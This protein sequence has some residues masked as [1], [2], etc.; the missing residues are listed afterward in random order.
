MVSHASRS[1]TADCGGFKRFAHSAGP[2]GGLEAWRRRG[3]E[4]KCLGG[5]RWGTWGILGV[6]RGAPGGSRGWVPEDSLGGAWEV[7]GMSLGVPGGPCGG[8]LGGSLGGPWGSWRDAKEPR[9]LQD[10][11]HDPFWSQ[12]GANLGQ[13][14]GKLGKTWTQM[15]PK[16]VPRK[17]KNQSKIIVVVSF[18]I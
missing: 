15:A 8:S 12:P 4:D 18:K 14:W 17:V 1:A 2:F 11:P 13:T 9:W 16:M 7:P 10:C 3:L 6:L 5:T